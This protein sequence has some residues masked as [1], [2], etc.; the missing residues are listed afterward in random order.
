MLSH[1]YYSVSECIIRS[2][3]GEEESKV[4]DYTE[5]PNH[6]QQTRRRKCGALLMKRVKI[7]GKLKLVP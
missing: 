3:L 4:C 7:N 2:V 1:V 6:S 5:F